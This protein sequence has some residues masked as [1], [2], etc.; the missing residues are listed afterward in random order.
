[1]A[2]VIKKG[3][4]IEDDI[5]KGF[6]DELKLSI[7]LI[8]EWDEG[9]KEAAKNTKANFNG[10]SAKDQ[11]EANK[12]LAT[13][14]RL[15]K[16][17]IAID[18]ELIKVKQEEEKLDQ[19]IEK[20]KQS[21]L[22]TQQKSRDATIKESKETERLNKIKERQAKAAKKNTLATNE[23]VKA[24]LK[25]QRAK[26][27][28]REALK[29]IIILEDKEASI[30]EKLTA[31]NRQLSRERD[32]LAGATRKERKAIQD[33]NKTIDANNAKIEKNA[34]ALKKQKI[35]IGRYTEGIRGAIGG[36]KGFASAL[37][38][39]G[40]I[41]LFTRG[42]RNAFNIV[43]NF[44][45]AQAD[46]S[47]VL[48]VTKDEMSALTEQAKKLGQTTKFTASEVSELQLEFAK[49]G[50]TQ[51]EIQDVT[52]ATLQLAAAAGTDLANAATVVGSTLRAFNLDASN[53]QRLV[54]VMAQSF[55]SSSLDIAKFSSSMS[56]VAPAA[57][58]LGLTIEETTALLGSLTDAGVDASSAGTGLR[59]MFLNAKEQ[60][61]TFDEAL[62][63]IANSTDKLG[64][65]FDIFKKKGSTLGVIL[66]NSRDSTAELTEKLLEAGG[67]A[68][69][70]A[71]KQLDTLQGQL[72]LLNSAWEGYILGADGATGASE[73][74]K[75]IISFL[76]ENLELIL[77][78][79]KKGVIVFASLKLAIKATRIAASLYAITLKAIAFAQVSL[80][81]GTKVATRAVKGFGAAM[82]GIPFVAII[83]AITTVVSLMWDMEDATDENNKRLEDE[84]D[85]LGKNTAEFI[86][87]TGALKKTIAGSKERSRLI[88]EINNKFG[89]T[90]KNLKDETEFQ[91]QVNEAV[92]N[93]IGLQKQKILLQRNQGEVNKHLLLQ[94]EAEEFLAK[95][96]KITDKITKKAAEEG[97][98]F[99]RASEKIMNGDA[100]VRYRTQLR[101]A[102]IE[103]AKLG[104]T[105]LDL[106]TDGQTPL[107]PE[108]TP[109]SGDDGK[110]EEELKLEELKLFKE[111]QAIKLIEHENYLIEKGITAEDRTQMMLDKELELSQETAVKIIEL[112]FDTNEILTK[113]RNDHLKKAEKAENDHLEVVQDETEKITFEDLKAFQ[114]AE[115]EKER[116][117][118]LALAREKE[119]IKELKEANEELTKNLIDGLIQVADTKREK[120]DSEIQTNRD[121]ITASQNEIARLNELGTADAARNITTQKKAIAKEKLEIEALEKKKINLLLTTVGLERASQLIGSGDLT[122]FKNASSDV[123]EFT[124]DLKSLQSSPSFYEGAEGTFAETLGATNTR[125]GHTVN[126]DDGEQILNGKKVDSLRAVGLRTTT[127]ITNAAI[128]NQTSQMGNKAAGATSYMFTDKNIVSK[129]DSVIDAFESMEFPVAYTNPKTGQTTIQKGGHIKRINHDFNPYSS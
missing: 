126:V 64:T 104:E 118:Q 128:M 62:D 20:S 94:I 13:S 15:R 31:R 90:L 41:Q 46:L 75:D 36:L 101:D 99:L 89:T 26:Q 63:K 1:M 112:D 85:L 114:K 113:H 35:G 10:N 120:L 45:Q 29:D 30:V 82:K 81:R 12:A 61:I 37:G 42:L 86:S 6:N 102:T 52:E 33:L 69:E 11:Q 54:D 14:T 22:K 40:G 49:L 77:N 103:L 80:T 115:N 119:R 59:N 97:I 18:K 44:D 27:K 95:H 9:V 4:I 88:T 24:T 79:I 110:T 124:I 106:L 39:V 55:S 67:A 129:L 38:I 2:K 47:S 60:G 96:Q 56:N 87:Y 78:A 74:L 58:A 121:E 51:R 108:S 17:V 34:D 8:K 3:E 111:L 91:N 93:Y 73:T 19:Q 65:S 25:L 72:S 71:D 57:A 5:L 53:T 84:K 105:A 100:V 117:R 28:Q 43:K 32:K 123:S 68:E 92:S 127:D 83:S 66:A 48:A 70:M 76:A 116:L 98:T 107:L 7:K 50:F 21:A 122:P 125:D 16:D 109:D 23:E